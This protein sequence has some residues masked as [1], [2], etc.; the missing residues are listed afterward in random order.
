M[1][2]IVG[3]KYFE[4]SVVGGENLLVGPNNFNKHVPEEHIP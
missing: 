2:F 4:K 3:I 1:S